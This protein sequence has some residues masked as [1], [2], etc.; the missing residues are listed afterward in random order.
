MTAVSDFITT[1]PYGYVEQDDFL[2]GCLLLDTLL[3]PEE[4]LDRLH[5][6]EQEE[7]RERLIHWGPRTLDLDI[8][9]YDNLVLDTDTLHIPHVE[10]HK[11]DFVL[12]PL[13]QIAPWMRHPLNG[14]TVAQM[15][16]E[17]ENFS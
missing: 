2:N 9:F 12:K 17:L 5:E 7:K 4:L 3:T 16:E 13:A 1:A 15:L 6:I 8:I 14:K 11:R 10:M